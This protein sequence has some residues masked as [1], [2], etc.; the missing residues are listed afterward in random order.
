MIY[1]CPRPSVFDPGLTIQHL[2]FWL[3]WRGTSW[4][5]LA[6]LLL[7]LTFRTNTMLSTKHH[8]VSWFD[9]SGDIWCIIIL[10]PTCC[11]SVSGCYNV[12]P[13]YSL[14]N[15]TLPAFALIQFNRR[16]VCQLTRYRRDADW[17]FQGS[18]RMITDVYMCSMSC[19]MYSYRAVSLIRLK[20]NDSVAQRYVTYNNIKTIGKQDK[21]ITQIIINRYCLPINSAHIISTAQKSQ[22]SKLLKLLKFPQILSWIYEHYLF[23]SA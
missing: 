10:A 9:T 6:V 16:N 7:A 22:Q 2:G 5:S 15:L 17:I 4:Y 19:N 13:S 1:H 23:I 14:V 18:T 21:N 11:I 12:S 8:H 3:L 20:Y